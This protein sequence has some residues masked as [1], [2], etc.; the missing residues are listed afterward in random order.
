MN[1]PASQRA[2]RSL[3]LVDASIYVFRAYY[4]IPDSMQNRTGE[5]T[6]AVYGY[7]RFLDELMAR[8]AV[9]HIGVAFDESLSRSFRNKI[10]PAYKANREPAPEELKRQFRWCKQLTE[11]MGV[12]VYSSKRYEA[13]DLI[14]TIAGRMRRKK[15]DITVVSGDKD[16]MQLIGPRDLFL[17]AGRD[18]RFGYHDVQGHLGV[19]PE[20]VADFLALAGDAVDNIPGVPGIGAKTAAQLLG[21]YADL[22][23]IYAS[24]HDIPAM[25]MR[26]AKRVAALLEEH[27]ELAFLSRR[28]TV[29]AADAP[30][31][32]GVRML[33]R[34]RPDAAKLKRLCKRLGFSEGMRERLTAG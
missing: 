23:A 21:A 4:S 33:T 6:N 34:R 31:E 28:L 2:A 7:A 13:D 24:L 22:E 18:R 12:T 30:V 32:T 17:D 16:L 3:F 26:G 20:Q 11:A 8:H 27:R 9:T 10:Y 14:A 29:A 1:R 15:F 25:S 19:M 5:P